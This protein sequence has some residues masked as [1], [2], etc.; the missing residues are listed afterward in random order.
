MD[1][2]ASIKEIDAEQYVI[3]AVA[4]LAIF[5]PG[6]LAFAIMYPSAFMQ[7]STVKLVLVSFAVGLP[8]A[9][10]SIVGVAF[11]IATQETN[12][13][14]RFAI[15]PPLSTILGSF[16][17]MVWAYIFLSFAFIFGISPKVFAAL[18]LVGVVLLTVFWRYVYLRALNE[19]K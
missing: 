1:I 3:A 4:F 11:Y 2:L 13:D 14:R 6:M 18:A 17:T 8:L 19:T 10:P 12:P 9:I 5:A 16:F 15:I 7:V